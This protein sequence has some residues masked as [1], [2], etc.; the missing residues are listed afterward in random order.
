MKKFWKNKKVFITGHTGF[1]GSWLSMILLSY[2][3]KVYGLSLRTNKDKNLIFENSLLNKKCKNFFFDILN[4]KK[5]NNIVKKIKPD[6][7]FHLAAQPFV[8]KGYKEPKKTFEVNALGTL[9]ILETIKENKIKTS[10]IITTDKVYKNNNLRKCF[11]ENDELGGSD[12][13]SS[14]KHIAEILVENYNLNYFIESKLNVVTARAGNVIGG[15]DRGENRLIPD[16]FKNKKNLIIRAPNSTRPWQFILDPLNGYLK[17]AK[18]IHGKKL[19][20][21][22]YSWNFAPNNKEA[23]NV[24][25]VINLLNKSFNKKIIYN[26]NNF[27]KKYLNLKSNK[28]KKYLKWSCKYNLEASLKKIIEWEIDFKNNNNMLCE[29]QIN[30]FFKD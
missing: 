17:L 5:L 27:E 19:K 10:V 25:Y 8:I 7:L 3:A 12:P 22:Q 26:N 20:K 16:F 1:K 15:G 13:Y 6:I 18:F 11:E 9:N 14:S 2:G 24:R 21:D 4:Y 30:E 23:K 29:K 28:S